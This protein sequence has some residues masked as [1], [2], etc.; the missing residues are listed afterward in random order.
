MVEDRLNQHLIHYKWMRFLFFKADGQPQIFL[1]KISIYRAN[2]SVRINSNMD[3]LVVYRDRKPILES[4]VTD[5]T[6]QKA[7]Y[8]LW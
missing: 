6:W 4:A 1:D 2:D 5:A 3:R 7:S 8:T